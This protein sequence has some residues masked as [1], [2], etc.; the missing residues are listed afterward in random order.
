MSSISVAKAKAFPKAQGVRK[1]RS[2][3]RGVGYL[4]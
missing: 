3:K 2:P 1:V 4:S